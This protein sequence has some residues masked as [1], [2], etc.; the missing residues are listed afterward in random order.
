MHG[1]SGGG[2]QGMLAGNN[3]LSDVGIQLTAEHGADG[4]EQGRYHGRIALENVHDISILGFALCIGDGSLEYKDWTPDP[5]FPATT[6][7]APIAGDDGE[8]LC[9][10]AF[11]D[12]PVN[13]DVVTMGILE[14]DV[15]GDEEALSSSDDCTLV[16]GE[17]MDVERSVQR[18][19]GV[20]LLV[21]EGD[22]PVYGYYLADN[23]PNPF[24]IVLHI[25]VNHLI[26]ICLF[27]IS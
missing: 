23:Y 20:E 26:C 8:V 17:V 12:G 1:Y 9:I 4:S 19:R 10:G 13:G 24:N 15:K 18:I 27:Y 2:Q 16:F 3:L 25:R 22:A 6:I 5:G 14:F 11:G 7:V 21:E